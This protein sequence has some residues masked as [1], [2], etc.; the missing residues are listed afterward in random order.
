[1]RIRTNFVSNSSSTSYII[2]VTRDF[3]PA[4]EQL[5]EFWERLEEER[6]CT[7]A[8][9]QGILNNLINELCTYNQVW[10]EDGPEGIF[11][12]DIFAQE[13][14]IATV[15]GAPD[16]GAYVNVLSDSNKEKFMGQMKRIMG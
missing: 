15:D 13:L 6:E 16:C 8:E 5:K 11:H 7:L 3:V 2:A 1:M 9:A 4:E 12:F 14:V 10:E